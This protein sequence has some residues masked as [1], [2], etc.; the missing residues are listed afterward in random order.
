MK[1]LHN[2]LDM[3]YIAATR[4][5]HTKYVTPES[6]SRIVA[7]LKLR[8]Y[9]AIQICLLLLLLLLLEYLIP[10]DKMTKIIVSHWQDYLIGFDS[11]ANR[12]Q[13]LYYI[14]QMWGIADKIFVFYCGCKLCDLLISPIY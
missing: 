1:L 14:F 12:P 6:R 2:F 11:T 5:A 9:G 4:T 13:S 10:G 8:P 7:P 3:T